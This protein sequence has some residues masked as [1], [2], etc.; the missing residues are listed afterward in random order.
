MKAGAHTLREVMEQPQ[1]WAQALV[2]ARDFMLEHQELLQAADELV[3]VGCGSAYHICLCLASSWRAITGRPATPAT[4]SELSLFPEQYLRVGVEQ[5]MVCP[6]RSGETSETVRA[7]QVG[8]NN[9]LPT[10]A[11]TAYEGS[12]LDR[13]SSFTLR[14]PECREKSTITT[15]SVTA[16]ILAGAVMARTAAELDPVGDLERLPAA[17]ERV[18]A[19]YGGLAREIG[20]APHLDKIAYLGSGPLF[21]PAQEA[22][23]KVQEAALRQAEAFPVLDFRHGP[24]AQVD[25][26]T[27]VVAMISEAGARMEAKVLSEMRALGATTIAIAEQGDANLA[28]AAHHVVELRSGVDDYLRQALYL[29]IPHLI[30]YHK[31]LAVGENPDSPRNLV[32]AVRL[33]EEQQ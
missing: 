25:A 5:L 13:A 1:V 23:L 6:S 3:C 10:I 26:R 2:Q 33:E 18:L 31:A 22:R 32:Y 15:K 4:G 29:P 12:S 28:Q 24:M 17:C 11:F 7:V 30:A 9:G 8:K 19:E 27:L 16:M 14:L 20:T 21:G